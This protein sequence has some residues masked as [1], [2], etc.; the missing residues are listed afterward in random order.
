VFES[1]DTEK[2]PILLHDIPG[3]PGAFELA[4]KF[5]YH[6]SPE[7][8]PS[9]VAILRCVAKYLEMVDNLNGDGG[10]LI[11]KTENYLNSVVVGYWKDSI[12]VFKTC[13]NLKPWAEDLQIVRCCESVAWKA[14]TDPHGI[15]WSFSSKARALQDADAAAA[16]RDWWFNDVSTLSIDI[17]SKLISVVNLKG[18]QWLLQLLFTMLRNGSQGCL[19]SQPCQQHPRENLLKKKEVLQHS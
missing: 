4:A 1:R 14:S 8:K 5:L 17:F 16:P 12:Y 19:E 10:N 11:M 15:R 2:E 9:N 18:M 13:S 6:G 3:G 7:I